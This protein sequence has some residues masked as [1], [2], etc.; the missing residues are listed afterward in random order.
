MSIPQGLT[1]YRAERHQKDFPVNRKYGYYSDKLFS[2]FVRASHEPFDNSHK[3]SKKRFVQEIHLTMHDKSLETTQAIRLFPKY[4]HI[5]KCIIQPLSCF[6]EEIPPPKFTMK[7]FQRT[8][9]VLKRI[10]ELKLYFSGELEGRACKSLLLLS[11]LESLSLPLFSYDEKSKNMSFFKETVRLASKRR[12]WKNFRSLNIQF[13]SPKISHTNRCSFNRSLRE[14]LLFLRGLRKYCREM[15]KCSSFQLELPTSTKMS[16]DEPE[17][18]LEIAKIA[19]SMTRIHGFEMN[20]FAGLS[21]MI[22]HFEGLKEVSLTLSHGFQQEPDLSVL[23]KM[24]G[25]QGLTLDVSKD[26]SV[27]LLLC[28]NLLAQVQALKNLTTLSLKFHAIPMITFEGKTF[29]MSRTISALTQLKSLELFFGDSRGFEHP[30]PSTGVWLVDALKAIGEKL[31]LEKLLLSFSMSNFE[32]P[33]PVFKSFSQSVK[34]LTGLSVLKLEVLA[35]N[36]IGDEDLVNLCHS[37]DRLKNIQDLTL[38]ISKQY[39]FKIKTLLALL[40]CFVSNFP[41]LSKL[42]LKISSVR[43]TSESYQLISGAISKMRCLNWVS[44]HLTGEI[45]PGLDLKNLEA[46]INR[47]ISGSISHSKSYSPYE[48]LY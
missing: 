31:Q 37:M 48:R 17:I 45:E 26:E 8:F 9:K 42:D 38:K 12:S 15:Y 28:K 1:L 41:F 2:S 3:R 24:P 21:K 35:A 27:D 44:L 18:L 39:Y 5:K 34:K 16:V 43:T 25:F 6:Y 29:D 36:T 46:E 10:T 22:E 11:D 32:N 14:L 23:N 40:D 13:S 47:K 33:G 19:P 30:K 7:E 20:K 4:H